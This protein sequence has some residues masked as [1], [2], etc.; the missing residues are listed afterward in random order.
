[1]SV[2]LAPGTI[3][4]TLSLTLRTRIGTNPD[5]TRC[6]GSDASHSNAA[7]LR[8]YFDSVSRASKLQ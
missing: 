4:G 1:V 2:T 3:N 5:G 7:G 6:S 8:V